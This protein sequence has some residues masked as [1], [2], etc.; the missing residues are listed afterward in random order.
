[1][2]A[3]TADPGTLPIYRRGHA[4]THLR[5]YTQ[6]KAVGLCPAHISKPDAVYFWQR[7]PDGTPVWMWLYDVGQARAYICTN[8]HASAGKRPRVNLRQSGVQ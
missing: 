4:P 7:K 3:P 1:M 2:A 6:L 8:K 5:T